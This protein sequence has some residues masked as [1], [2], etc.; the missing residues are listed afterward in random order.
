MHWVGP[1][2]EPNDQF[3]R[4]ASGLERIYRR[5]AARSGRSQSIGDLRVSV[6][7]PSGTEVVLHNRAGASDDSLVRTF[8]PTPAL[9]TLV[10][11]PATGQWK[12]KVVDLEKQD[13][14]KLNS[15][16]LLIKPAAV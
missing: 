11:Q 4:T 6:V 5:V 7:S 16:R 13:V 14:G 12:L 2:T 9:A 1:K 15:W 8:T 10:G 3:R